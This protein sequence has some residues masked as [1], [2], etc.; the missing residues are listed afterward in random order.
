M[1]RGADRLRVGAPIVAGGI[2]PGW[3]SRPQRNALIGHDVA[4]AALLREIDARTPGTRRRADGADRRA[5]W[6]LGHGASCHLA[7]KTGFLSRW[8]RWQQAPRR[9]ASRQ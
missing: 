4:G 7:L 1:G 8:A 2:D 5:A 6:A 9:E 3:R